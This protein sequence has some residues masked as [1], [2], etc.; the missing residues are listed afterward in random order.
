MVIEV[1]DIILKMQ[2]Y[3]HGLEVFNDSDAR[4]AFGSK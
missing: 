4:K 1:R 2:C 3:P